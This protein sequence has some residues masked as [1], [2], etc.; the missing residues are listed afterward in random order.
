ML[1]TV[2]SLPDSPVL[3][4]GPTTTHLT[5]SLPRDYQNTLYIHSESKSGEMLLSHAIYGHLPT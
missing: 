1:F 3:E 2:T 5:R 4:G